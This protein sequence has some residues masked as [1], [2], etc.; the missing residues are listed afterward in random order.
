MRA[1]WM[2]VMAGCLVAGGAVYARD[3]AAAPSEHDAKM[4]KMVEFA[5]PGEAHKALEPLIGAWDYTM[6]WWESPG[7]EAQQS[8]GVST[9]EWILGNRFVQ[10]KAS[11]A[12]MGQPF[13]G[14]GILGYDNMKKTYVSTWI[15]SMG[16][17]M[18]SST[19]SYDPATRS[20]TEE[21]V[22]SCPLE[23]GDKKVRTITRLIDGNSYVTEMY[24]TDAPSGKEFKAMEL[25][26]TRQ[27]GGN[28]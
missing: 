24:M 15:D 25:K 11:G 6:T 18:M 27:K 14:T 13:E 28:S 23:G 21:G 22:F 20:L 10:S 9:S 12:A 4:T 16:T 1:T 26:Y 3:D 7:S 19:G 2:W 8:A 17:G 5:T